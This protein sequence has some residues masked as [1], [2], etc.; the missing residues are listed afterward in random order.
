M[1]KTPKKRL[2]TNTAAPRGRRC[3]SRV[4]MYPRKKI[5]S[6]VPARTPTISTARKRSGPTAWASAWR[7]ITMLPCCARPASTVS[8]SSVW[9]SASI[10]TT[11]STSVRPLSRPGTRRSAAAV[12]L[13]LAI[14]AVSAN[15]AG[16]ERP[17]EP[18]ESSHPR[19]EL[20]DGARLH[21]LQ[22]RRRLR[23]HGGDQHVD[24]GEHLGDELSREARPQAKRLQIVVGRD[25]ESDLE[26]RPNRG[27]ELVRPLTGQPRMQGRGLRARDD[28]ADIDERPR[29]GDADRRDERA[30]AGEHTGGRPDRGVHL[31]VDAV[32]VVVLRD[33]HPQPGDGALE[34][35]L[36][37]RN[38]ASA[39]RRVVRILPGDDLEDQR[40]VGDRAR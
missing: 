29:I 32:E 5:S 24:L 18:G 12:A 22:S 36:V 7:I 21:R 27:L 10:P 37:V 31:G 39:R 8:E 3:T 11:A 35:A 40:R 14:K 33:S 34:Q 23:D 13:P 4:C 2:V 6:A 25:V 16:V 1:W 30:E 26:P 15:A 28:V 9:P 19:D 17:R 38:A 20:V